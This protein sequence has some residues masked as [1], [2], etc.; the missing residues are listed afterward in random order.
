LLFSKTLFN[1]HLRIWSTFFAYFPLT[2]LLFWNFWIW[3]PKFSDGF[4]WILEKKR[5]NFL[6]LDVDVWFIYSMVWL[7]KKNWQGENLKLI[8]DDIWSTKIIRDG[9][10][11]R[12]AKGKLSEG[13]GGRPMGALWQFF[14][15]H[16]TFKT[17]KSF[18]LLLDFGYFKFK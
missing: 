9:S 13:K 7:I 16:I 14:L 18:D 8:W 10:P 5:L 15:E 4:R 1:S 11:L 6:T 2:F 12:P 3:N 17:M